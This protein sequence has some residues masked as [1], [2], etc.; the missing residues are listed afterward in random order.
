M[1][2]IVFLVAIALLPFYGYSQKTAED[3][4]YREINIPYKNSK[5][6]I[7][8]RSKPG[9][10]D[11][12]K[13][14]LLYCQGSLAQPVL[15]YDERG[16]YGVFPFGDKLFIDMYHMIVIGKP[17]V[18]VIADATQLGPD[19]TYL[20]D[21]NLPA[22]YTENNYLTY[23]AERNN[24][25]INQLIKEPWAD[26]KGLVLAAHSEGTYVATKMAV[27]N[28]NVSRLILSSGNPYGRMASIVAQ[29]RYTGNDGQI[30]E[31]WR[32]IVEDKDNSKNINGNDSFKTTYSF[33]N[34]I[35]DDLM[36]LKIPVLFCYGTKDWSAPYND[37]FQIEAIRRGKK[38]ISFLAYRGL[39]HNYFPV[40]D[41]MQADYSI[42][43]WSK[44]AADWA[45]WLKN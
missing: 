6:K 33:S 42:D 31:Y 21:G 5:V 10:E 44:L 35:V 39:E 2:Q 38:N 27:S 11:K 29:E 20:E 45:A 28:K 32:N 16:L 19:Y 17:G 14:L 43:N 40:N 37:L 1:K 15:K 41:M 9:E 24:T 26:T 36:A 25:I 22:D 13:P 3:F 18:P 12:K 30:M 8:V 34:P 7:I 4:G 23:Y